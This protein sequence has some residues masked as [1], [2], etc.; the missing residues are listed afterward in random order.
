MKKFFANFLLIFSVLAAGIIATPWK[1]YVDWVPALSGIE[2][3]VEPYTLFIKSGLGALVLVLSVVYLFETFYEVKNYGKAKRLI[4]SA[5]F[6]PMLVLSFAYLLYAFPMAFQDTWAPGFNLFARLPIVALPLAM[7]NIVIYGHYFAGQFRRGS[8]KLRILLFFFALQLML[9]SAFVSYLFFQ[10]TSGGVFI[11]SVRYYAFILPLFLVFYFIHLIV[12]SIQKKKNPVEEVSL[13]EEV[14]EI[15]QQVK[16]N[17]AKKEEPS[18]KP[19]KHE[20]KVQAKQQAVAQRDG[21]KT[22][23]VSKQQTI[24]SSEH[25]V[26]PTNLLYEDVSVDPEFN[27]TQNMEKQISTIDYYIEKPKLLKPL[28]PQFDELVQYIRDLPTVVTKLADERITFYVDRKPFMVLMNF[29]NYYRMVFR[30]DLEKGIRLII[31][32]PTIS[33]NKASKEDLWFKANNYGDLPREIVFDIAKSAFDNV[34]L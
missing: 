17:Q 33:K 6:L 4:T 30:A 31:K 24:I 32:Y 1:A 25:D 27:K 34:N 16:E 13:E 2:A 18:K 19:S 11:I 12:V 7:L 14:K 26:D 28:D 15:K 21:K 9:V 5:A 20:L 3:I 29:G 8:N 10:R 23:I 22:L